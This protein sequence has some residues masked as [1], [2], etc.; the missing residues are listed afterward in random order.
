MHF[1]CGRKSYND[2]INQSVS[3]RILTSISAN[4]DGPHDA[5][6]CKIDHI[7]LP[8]KYNYQAVSIG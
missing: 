7:A 3:E 5:A 8:T 4:V 2:F 6:S 1:R